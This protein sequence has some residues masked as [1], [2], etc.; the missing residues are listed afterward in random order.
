[1]Q[2][3]CHCHRKRVTLTKFC[4]PKMISTELATS[5]PAIGDPNAGPYCRYLLIF[6]WSLL[7]EDFSMRLG[8]V[9]GSYFLRSLV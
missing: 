9:V 5:L 2:M 8:I 4:F 1:M 6:V 3:Q 7:A